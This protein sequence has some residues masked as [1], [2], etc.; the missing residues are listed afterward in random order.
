MEEIYYIMFREVRMF[1]VLRGNV[2]F[3]F[4]LRK[5]NRV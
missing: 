4:D 2:K 5:I 1:F 3:N